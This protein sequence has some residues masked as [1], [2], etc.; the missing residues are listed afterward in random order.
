[1]KSGFFQLQTAEDLF[2]KLKWELEEL[3][4]DPSNPWRAYN[5]LV[6]AEHLPD[7]VKNRSLR[8]KDA[9]LRVCSHLANGGKHFDVDRHSSV[10]SAERDGVFEEGAFEKGVFEEW[11]KITLEP[12]EAKEL[13]C[14]EVD[15]VFLAERLVKWWSQYFENRKQSGSAT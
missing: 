1:M 11:L 14:N 3:R 4:K 9:L 15:A 10:S 5:F 6:T 12:D 2:A 13:G 8:K 7:W